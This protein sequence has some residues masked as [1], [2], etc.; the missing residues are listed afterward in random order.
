MKIKG[1]EGK[2]TKPSVVTYQVLTDIFLSI[3]TV[4]FQDY[5]INGKIMYTSLYA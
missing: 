1:Q 2:R 5:F 4:R 3:E